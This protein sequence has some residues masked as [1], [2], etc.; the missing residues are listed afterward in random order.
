MET[1]DR[2]M[3]ADPGFLRRL[4]GHLQN[5][6]DSVSDPAL[7]SVRAGRSVRWRER[8]AAYGQVNERAGHQ[9]P[10]RA[11]PDREGLGASMRSA[12][13]C[14]GSPPRF[15]TRK[16]ATQTAITA[17][18]T[19]LVRNAALSFGNSSRIGNSRRRQGGGLGVCSV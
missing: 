4:G 17:A 1:T 2:R 11:G 9:A 16:M 7:G 10:Q 8:T 19:G 12:V 5:G 18:L 6:R 3:D 13:D 15:N 14:S